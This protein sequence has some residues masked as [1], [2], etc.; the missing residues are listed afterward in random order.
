[1]KGYTN[2]NI[3]FHRMWFYIGFLWNPAILSFF[4]SVPVSH[5]KS[6][7]PLWTCFM[8][9][10][11]YL[12]APAA[13]ILW[14]LQLHGLQCAHMTPLWAKG[15][16]NPKISDKTTILTRNFG[17]QYSL[18]KWKCITPFSFSWLRNSTW[19]SWKNR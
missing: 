10:I 17:Q 18:K 5:V 1:M 15:G 14:H 12:D 11:L 19:D 3:F 13:F 9:L 7:V 8:W 6:L 2:T 4:N 16:V